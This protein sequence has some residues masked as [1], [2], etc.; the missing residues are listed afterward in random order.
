MLGEGW[1]GGVLGGWVCGWGWGRK[2]DKKKE[3]SRVDGGKNSHIQ[4]QVTRT[5]WGNRYGGGTW[6]IKA[7][8][9]VLM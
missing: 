3:V 9:R 8:L 7:S 4:K 5:K 6:E 2:Q 1:G